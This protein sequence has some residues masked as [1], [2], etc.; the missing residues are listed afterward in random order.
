MT[1]IIGIEYKDS[2]FLVADSQTTD[3]SGK[4]YSHPNVKKI[5]ERGAF[6]VAGS[7]EV[8]PCD[9]AQHIWEPPTPA[10]KD[11]QDLYHFM[12][13]KAMPSLRKCLNENG[14]NFDESKSE[15]RF[16]FLIAV[17]GEIFDVDQELCV[18]MSSDGMYAVG[19]GGAY[20]LGALH[21]GVDAYQALE[22]AAKITAFTAG[23]YYSK[24]Q[25]KHFK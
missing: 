23:P 9:V 4:I 5:A 12:I 21:A 10:K 24:T 15:G 2:C 20:A 6:L 11:R 22:I 17:C 1:T 3:D 13:S 7:G 25:I 14:Y 18:S 19:S 8:L 16:Q